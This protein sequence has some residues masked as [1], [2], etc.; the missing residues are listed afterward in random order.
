MERGCV[1][2]ISRSG[3]SEA[4]D[5]PARENARPT[6]DGTCCGWVF[7]HSRAPGNKF[8][9]DFP[10]GGLQASGDGAGFARFQRGLEMQRGARGQNK[11][12]RPELQRAGM[13][14]KVQ[15]KS[16]SLNFA[17][18]VSTWFYQTTQRLSRRAR[19][20]R[21]CHLAE[22]ANDVHQLPCAHLLLRP[23]CFLLN[24]C[25]G[26]VQVFR[27]AAANLYP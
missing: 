14:E 7:A 21:Q 8:N 11:F 17:P 5:E 6:D 24:L 16:L 22:R 18:K 23:E 4:A 20:K 26:L 27:F 12:A 1:R 25:K 19:C 13:W 9:A 3:W 15:I 10:G 2:R